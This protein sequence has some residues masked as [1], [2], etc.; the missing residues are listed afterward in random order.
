MRPLLLTC[1]WDWCSL[2][3]SAYAEKGIMWLLLFVV[4]GID[5]NAFTMSYIPDSFFL[6]LFHYQDTLW[7]NE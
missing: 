5:S 3:A 1:Y 2:R 7:I 4:M 6:F